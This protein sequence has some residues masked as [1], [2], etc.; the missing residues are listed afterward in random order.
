[1]TRTILAVLLLA[2]SGLAPA[3]S[4]PG[5]VVQYLQLDRLERSLKLAPDQKEQ[6]DLAVGATKRLM[7][8]LT[9]AAMEGKERLAAE[10]AKPSP[11]FRALERLG[12]QVM[13]ESRTLR[14]EARDE[15]MKL[16][17][18]LDQAQIAELRDFLQRRVDHLGLLNDFLRGMPPATRP[19]K[20]APTYW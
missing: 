7:L 3:A 2:F 6:Y 4:P 11:D 20:D 17:A 5:D 8:G 18:M 15:W 9:I 14:G 12:D 10:L 1:M 19:K 13:E 16:Y